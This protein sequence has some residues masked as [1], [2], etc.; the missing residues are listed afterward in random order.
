MSVGRD[1]HAYTLSTSTPQH[2]FLSPLI[3]LWWLQT[4]SIWRAISVRVWWQI[5]EPSGGSVWLCDEKSAVIQELSVSLPSKKAWPTI[6]VVQNHFLLTPSMRND[7]F[8]H[9]SLL[10][11]QNFLVLLV[12]WSVSFLLLF[13]RSL[14][15]TATVNSTFTGFHGYSHTLAKPVFAT[16]DVAFLFLSLFFFNCLEFALIVCFYSSVLL[17][18]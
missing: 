5:L 2:S 11:I 4:F 1:T 9:F 10:L 13:S 17:P 16:A 15:V 7:N 14:F 8:W 12:L 3:L 18:S 6:P